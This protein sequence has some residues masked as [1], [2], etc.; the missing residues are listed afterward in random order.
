M[1]GSGPKSGLQN[2]NANCNL[3]LKA[4]RKSDTVLFGVPT[5]PGASWSIF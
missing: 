5:L 3:Q 1:I 4:Q 2:Q